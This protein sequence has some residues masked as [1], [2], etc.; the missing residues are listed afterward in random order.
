MNRERWK[1]KEGCGTPHAGESTRTGE[2]TL[3]AE[4]RVGG[5]GRG[6]RERRKLAAIPRCSRAVSHSRRERQV[7]RDDG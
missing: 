6:G 3:E 7:G 2:V 1:V 4:E 5:V